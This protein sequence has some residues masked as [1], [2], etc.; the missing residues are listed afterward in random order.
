MYLVAN[1]KTTLISYLRKYR[2]KLDKI[3]K[4]IIFQIIGL[5]ASVGVG[6]AKNVDQAVQHIKSLMA[7]LDSE[8]ICAVKNNMK[9]LRS[10]V[11]VPDEGMV[12]C[13]PN[14]V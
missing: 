1:I 14:E 7:N 13:Y 8:M 6:K 2:Q 4:K 5:T 10:Y 12:S 11:N 9:E 3:H